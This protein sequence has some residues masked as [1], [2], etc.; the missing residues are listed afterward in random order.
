M[1]ILEAIERA[2]QLQKS[3][4]RA[5]AEMTEVPSLKR[6]RAPGGP[7]IGTPAGLEFPESAVNWQACVQRHL[8]VDGSREGVDAGAADA[9]KILRT[10]LWHLMEV[11]QWHSLGV[12]SAGVGEG[13][14]T[15]ALNLALAM[16]S[17]RSRN[18][19]LLDLDLRRPSLCSYLGLTPGVDVGAYL[20]GESNP[21]DLFCSIGIPCLAVAGS[22]E[23]G[24]G[25][26]PLFEDERPGKLAGAETL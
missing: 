13:K 6:A 1:T 14:S 5:A 15:T 24:R 22:I 12:T 2:K 26:R 18:I 10:R 25:L 3:N 8:L 9:Y 23:E 4:K 20:R 16:A 11:N 19:F 17:E 21:A 7:P